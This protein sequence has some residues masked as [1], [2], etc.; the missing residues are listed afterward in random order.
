MWSIYFSGNAEYV[1]QLVVSYLHR[2]ECHCTPHHYQGHHVLMTR[3]VV[4]PLS[5]QTEGATASYM[6]L[7]CNDIVY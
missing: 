3:Y 2:P 5:S 4:T 7:E 1:I 6:T